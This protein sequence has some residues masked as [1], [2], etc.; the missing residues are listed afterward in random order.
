MYSSDE[1]GRANF[2]HDGFCDKGAEM[3]AVVLQRGEVRG[4]MVEK[5]NGISRMFSR[6]HVSHAIAHPRNM[7]HDVSRLFF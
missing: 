5:G 6:R 2:D 1:S 3:P 7:I 4:E